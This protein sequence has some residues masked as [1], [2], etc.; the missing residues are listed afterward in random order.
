MIESSL[1]PTYHAHNDTYELN[2]DYNITPTLV[3]TSST[4]YNSDQLA[5]TEDYNRFNTAPG[6]FPSLGT[7]TP[8]GV[9]CDPQLGCS[10]RIVGEDLSEEHARQFSEEL[11]L[12][13]HF[14]GPLNFSVG[15]NYLHYSTLEDYFVF[16]NLITA[17]VQNFNGPGFSPIEGF[18][19]AKPG[20]FTC[21]GNPV[22]HVSGL[23]DFTPEIPIPVLSSISLPS[24]F[25]C[26]TPFI[27]PQ[28]LPGTYIDPNPI[29]HLDG[30]GHNYFRSEN[31]YHLQSWAGFGEAYYQ[32]TPD[33]KLTGGLRWTDDRKIFYEIPSFV[34]LE[35]WGYPVTN[36]VHQQW[37]EWTG[38][39]NADW[40]PRLDFTDQTLFY[41][42]YSRGYKGGG[43]NPPPPAPD[44]FSLESISVT[45]PLTF[46]PEFVNAYEI[47]SKNSLLDGS[48]T[49]NGDIFYYDYMGYQISQIV[50]RTS[51]NL[52]FNAKV[53]GA[54]IEGTWEPVAG[55]RF[56]FAG[57]LEDSSVDNGQS[58]IDLIDRT[59]GH[60]DWV[61]VEPDVTG[62]ANCILPASVVSKLAANDNNLQSTQLASL[63][64]ACEA[65]YGN[66]AV[67]NAIGL[68]YGRDSYG[69]PY[70][71]SIAPNNG[72]GFSK[73]LGGNKLPNT[74]PFTLSIGAQYSMPLSPDWAATAR[75][76]GYWQGN[77]FA[78]I[79]ND[80]PYDQLRGY[81]NLN[82]T[83]I[84]TN[85]DGWQ[86]MA[87]MKNV[88]DTTAITGAFLNSD[89]SGLTTNVFVTD[90]RLF[91]IRITK[92]W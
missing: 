43:A 74:P 52:N 10:N 80:R 6:I 11:R 81:T 29:N 73:N 30:N 51:I 77:S 2:A 92:N 78:R 4:G 20:D 24:A 88:F 90:P 36:I 46:A 62:T 26:P 86:A 19:G 21:G 59:A 61:V 48:M 69:V 37:K 5:S 71:P 8:N 66:E 23:F 82:L 25:G 22:P 64:Y 40:S 91:G 56:N 33:V 14:D 85:Q 83:L 72:A 16:Y 67:A 53:K 15:A 60:S 49:L 18:P 41:A 75:A 32:V 47:G 68:V 17:E 12:E 89:D 7:L 79:F 58:A 87:Y 1:E 63:P 35:G 54:E 27:L 65:A 3:A 84:F 55:L 34:F 70:D 9:Y 76:D 44:A 57:G 50:D 13:S 28:G 31:P 39:L 42:S 38:R 45:H